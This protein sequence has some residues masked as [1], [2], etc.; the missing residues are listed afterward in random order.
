MAQNRSTRQGAVR[1]AI[2]VIGQALQR[3]RWAVVSHL[4]PVAFTRQ[5][6]CTL[7]MVRVPLRNAR[8]PGGQNQ[9]GQMGHY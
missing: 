2:W 3:C 8:L 6:R 7:L 4:R 5:L 1:G 9:S